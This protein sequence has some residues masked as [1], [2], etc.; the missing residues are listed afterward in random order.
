MNFTS[1][2]KDEYTRLIET[3]E[4]RPNWRDAIDRRARAIL[5]NKER[6]VAVSNLLGGTIPWYFIG[7]IHSMESG[8]SFDGVLHNGEK[9][10]GTG[11]KTKLVPRGRGPFTTWEDAAVDAL[12]IKKLEQI[13][14]WSDERMCYE[15][16]RFNGFGYRKYHPTVLSPYL[17]SGSTFYTQGK[18]VADGKW[19]STAKSGQSGA[20][21]LID[22]VRNIDVDKKEII[23][24][25]GKLSLIKRLKNL[26]S[27][28]TLT[29]FLAEWMGYL[30]QAK[31]FIVDNKSAVIWGLI[32][33]GT[34]GWVVFKFL[35]SKGINEYKEGRY[36]PS[37]QVE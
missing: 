7:S 29:G 8:L 34:A 28:V 6:Y 11:A 17:W 9:I 32:G 1:K 30:E 19:S 27:G 14:D 15:L 3:M 33:L 37:G 22:R 23:R 20:W 18:Y 16:E 24:E 35:E 26:F 25:S 31:E 2:L 36:I 4:V 5:A 21:L 13:T 10:L 12:K